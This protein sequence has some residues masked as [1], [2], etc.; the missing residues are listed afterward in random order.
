MSY[1]AR[2]SSQQRL[3]LVGTLLTMV[4]IVGVGWLREPSQES[5][6]VSTFSPQMTIR[7]LAPKIGATGFAIAKELHLPRSV[8]KDTPLAE[9]DIQQHQLDEVTEH[10]LSHRGSALKYYLFAALSLFGLVWL[11]RLGRPD[12][13]PNSERRTWYPRTPY[14]VA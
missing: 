6:A 9:L 14:L 11:V 13:S 12:G 8:D 7:Q 1:F 10:L 2:L 4:V 3:W 5:L